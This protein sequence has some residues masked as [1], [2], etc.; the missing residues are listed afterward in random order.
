MHPESPCDEVRNM[1]V[2]LLDLKRRVM[3]AASIAL[4]LSIP[5]WSDE[6]DAARAL[7]ARAKTAREG[8]KNYRCSVD[9][10]D[11]SDYAARKREFEEAGRTKDVFPEV[12]EFLKR[13]LDGPGKRYELQTIVGDS[14]GRMRITH[15]LGKVDPDGGR[16]VTNQ[17]DIAW[18]GAM[19]VHLT[20]LP[21]R[22]GAVITPERTMH[23]ALTRH[24]M[25]SFGDRFLTAMDKAMEDGEKIDMQQGADGLVQMRFACRDPLAD[26]NEGPKYL[27]AGTIDPSRGFT[28]PQWEFT[29]PNGNKSRFSATFTEISDGVWF[30]TEGR[31]EGFFADGMPNRRTSV[32]IANL[33]VNDPN[34]DAGAFH[35]NLP[36]G[37]HVTNRIAGIAYIVGDPT[38]TRALG[39]AASAAH[40][41]NDAMKG[42]DPSKDRLILLP[43]IRQAVEKGNS[44]V[45]DLRTGTLVGVDQA[46]TSA[47]TVDSLR[48]AGIGDLFWD[49]GIVVIGETKVESA[50]AEQQ[51]SPVFT[52][53]DGGGRYKLP[54]DVK[55]PCSLRIT[56]RRDARYNVVVTQIH[57]DGISITY[58]PV[59]SR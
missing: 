15:T 57:E 26:S 42:D 45:L 17:M 23:F 50:S 49:G 33:I 21:N 51:S 53:M 13:D 3:R 12:V 34:M 55:L 30:P 25:S 4:V 9:Y 56:D 2:R 24:P 41:V 6:N 27:W 11:E 22:D 7:F 47:E 29:L 39:D 8:L 5:G 1:R 19:N 54:Q 52:E 31:I 14:T 20:H 59:S 43:H 18:D 10:T 32:K 36:D 40:V 16:S 48:N 44:F 28:M 37:A 58:R 46:A 35:I 38:S